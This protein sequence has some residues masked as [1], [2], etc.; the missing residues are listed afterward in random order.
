MA[1]SA[2]AEVPEVTVKSK[3]RISKTLEFLAKTYESKHLSNGVPTRVV[4]GVYAPQHRPELSSE[5]GRRMD[6]WRTVLASE[7]PEAQELLG[8]KGD[9]VVRVG[10]LI[11]MWTT[12]ENR[13]A[14]RKE[15]L[16]KALMQREAVEQSFSEGID[17]V[18]APGM[19]PE[20]R[21]RPKGR[22][23]IEEKEFEFERDY[24]QPK[25]E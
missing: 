12:P 5:L 11:L 13:D 6:G 17:R 8:A 9:S 4:R 19:R 18:S 21:V 16:D 23:I 20:H 22:S 10:D 25:E 15:N 14:L 24:E 3:G 7:L 2:N 1:K